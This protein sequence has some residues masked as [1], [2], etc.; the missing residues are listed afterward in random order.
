MSYYVKETIGET[1]LEVGFQTL[2]E[3]KAFMRTRREEA[4]VRFEA[5]ITTKY[6]GGPDLNQAEMAKW[7]ANDE[8]ATGMPETELAAMAEEWR[9]QAKVKRATGNSWAASS[10]SALEQCANAID[11][12]Y[13][14]KMPTNRD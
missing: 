2:E 14:H 4:L 6:K 12:A 11:P 1:T 8:P 3:L 13:C 7:K 10:A 5:N 9:Q